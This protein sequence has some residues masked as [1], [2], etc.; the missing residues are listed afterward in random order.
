M[1]IQLAVLSADKFSV[2]AVSV[3][4][5]VKVEVEVLS[6]SVK[7]PLMVVVPVTEKDPEVL[8]SIVA[9]AFDNV[10]APLN[11]EFPLLRVSEEVAVFNVRAAA[12]KGPPDTVTPL[13]APIVRVPVP[14]KPAVPLKFIAA[15]GVSVP[16][17]VAV[18]QTKVAPVTLLNPPLKTR[19][20]AVV[21]ALELNVPPLL[22]TKPVNVFTPEFD[23]VKPLPLLI[24][25][26]PPNVTLFDPR[27]L[28]VPAV[29]VTPPAKAVKAVFTVMFWVALKVTAPVPDLL[30]VPEFVIPPEKMNAELLTVEK[31]PELVSK[32]VK[33]LVPVLFPSE[34]VPPEDIRVVPP[35]VILRVSGSRVP[36]I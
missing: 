1:K 8:T 28:K 6:L 24:V 36:S 9:P 21:I 11:E 30:K 31:V 4:A 23:M 33:V 10:S 2:P 34:K 26:V 20:A 7:V 29:I 12:V 14:V 18:G 22:V 3:T 27:I 35:I 25:N 5:P 13:P 15:P 16:V 32:P 19:L 17:T